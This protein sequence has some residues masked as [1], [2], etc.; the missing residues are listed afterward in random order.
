MID[1]TADALRGQFRA[2][3]APGAAAGGAPDLSPLAGRLIAFEGG[4]GAGKSTQLQRLAVDLRRRG[5]VDA[6]GQPRLVVTREPGGTE[7]GQS[8]R[9]W[10]L[11]GGEVAPEAEALLYAADRAQHV[12][13]VVR[14]AL[15]DG[16]LV[17]TDRYLDSSIAYQAEGRGLAEAL[18]RA[19]NQVATGGLT[20]DLTI[21]LDIGHQEGAERRAASEAPADRL[22][23]AGGGFHARVNA[24]YRQLA[25]VAAGR[26]AVIPARGPVEA[27]QRLV[28]LALERRLPGW[29]DPSA[30]SVESVQP[31]QVAGRPRGG[32]K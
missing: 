26:Y 23:R 3:V 32:A 21:L 31:G 11:D 14:P 27:V 18:V 8:I 30:G 25:A 19:V 20:P 9:S 7:L 1:Q 28:W 22:E 15:D 13:Q 4:D 6:P 12:A 29:S 24:R 2:A 17:M 16:A 10:L 5:L